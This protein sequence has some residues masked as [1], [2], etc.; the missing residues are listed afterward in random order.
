MR[1]VD[2]F[3]FIADQRRPRRGAEVVRLEDGESGLAA[4][5]IKRRLASVPGFFTYG[6][7]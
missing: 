5:T 4:R 7:S 6:P 3:S 2:I 1:T